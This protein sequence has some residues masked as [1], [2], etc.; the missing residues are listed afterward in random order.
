MTCMTMCSLAHTGEKIGNNNLIAIF[1]LNI[2]SFI[3][4]I[5]LFIVC[6]SIISVF[7]F[8]ENL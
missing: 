4:S 2:H 5:H 6:Y 8:P 1:S 3:I 7:V